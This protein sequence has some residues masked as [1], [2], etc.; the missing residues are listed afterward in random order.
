MQD[1]PT[2]GCRVREDRRDDR[3]V[4]AVRGDVDEDAAPVGGGFDRVLLGGNQVADALFGPRVAVGGVGDRRLGAQ[5]IARVLVAR[6]RADHLRVFEGGDVLGKAGGESAGRVAEQADDEVVADLEVRQGDAGI[7]Q[8]GHRLGGGEPVGT[9][10][11]CEDRVPVHVE[12]VAAQGLGQLG[13]EQGAASERDEHV[14]VAAHEAHGAQQ[15]G[16]GDGV[17]PVA[18]RGGADSQVDGACAVGGGALLGARDD[19]TGALEGTA[20]GNGFANEEAQADR[21]F[22]VELGKASGVRAGQG[23]RR[24]RRGVCGDVL[25]E[26]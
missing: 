20:Q 5:V 24:Q 25:V 6:E 7:T 21:V 11:L 13:G 15:G 14:V 4:V 23:Q 17:G 12:A 1:R 18:P 26:A 8:G 9:A 19:G 2:G 3:R 10:R 16:D 22:R